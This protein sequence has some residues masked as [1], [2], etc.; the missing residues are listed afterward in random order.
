MSHWH[1]AV[2]R[3]KTQAYWYAVGHADGSHEADC[4]DQFSQY[5]ERIAADF[6]HGRRIGMPSI[7]D[8][9]ITWPKPAGVVYVNGGPNLERFAL[10]VVH[11]EGIPRAIVPPEV[12]EITG[13]TDELVWDTRTFSWGNDMEAWKASFG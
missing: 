12:R 9:W 6:Y 1:E 4:A 11:V 7:R 10:L 8:L 2:Q 13:W 5:I 3:S